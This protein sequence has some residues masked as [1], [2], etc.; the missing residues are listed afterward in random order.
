LI[1][2]SLSCH[3]PAAIEEATALLAEHG[4]DAAVLGGGT[5][6]VPQM[7]RNERRV[8][9]L[10]DPRDL[11]LGEI[12]ER[13]GKIVIGAKVTYAQVLASE[14]ITSQVP[15]VEQ[16]AR[17]ITGGAQLRNLATLGGS[18]CYANPA[19]DVPG[20]LVA[21]GAEMSVAGPS[22]TRLVGAEEFFLDAFEPELEVGEMLTAI[23]IPVSTAAFGYFKLKRSETSWPIVTA[24]AVVPGWDER[25]EVTLGGVCAIPVRVTLEREADVD[26][27]V[28][29]ALGPPVGDVLASGSYRRDVAGAVARRALA[30]AEEGGS[31]D[32]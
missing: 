19:S 2:T 17:G 28:L 22:G 29:A 12:A 32:G 23:S 26:A 25:R 13:D 31:Q 24:A 15:M 9:H 1:R 30:V 11:G 10:I 7:T 8:L 5:L 4:A 20:V 6:L 27:T 3:R 16:M 14:L 18:A 21:L